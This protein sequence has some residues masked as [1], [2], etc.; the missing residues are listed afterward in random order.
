MPDAAQVQRSSGSAVLSGANARGAKRRL[1]LLLADDNGPFRDMLVWA[2]EDAGCEV[3]AV[4]NGKDLRELLASSL[5][6]DSAVEP[7]DIVVT[8]VRM[9][10]WTGL[11]AIESLS[12]VPEMPPVVVMTAFGDDET[13][14]SARNA[15]AVAILDKPIDPADLCALV[16]EMAR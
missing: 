3:V 14:N 11:H 15:G 2:F 6:P 1:R 7:F 8:D 13:K 16:H 5:R 9:P 4:G 10:G 12:G